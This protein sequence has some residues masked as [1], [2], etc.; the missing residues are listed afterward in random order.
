MYVTQKK[1]DAAI[2]YMERE[3]ER[4]EAKYWNMQHRHELLLRHLGLVEH[5]IPA[6]TELV[7]VRNDRPPHPTVAPQ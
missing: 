2:E 5:D 7:T 3:C 6:K 4:I 1:F